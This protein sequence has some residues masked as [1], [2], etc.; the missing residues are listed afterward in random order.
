VFFFY[1][2]SI[3]EL[4]ATAFLWTPLTTAVKAVANKAAAVEAVGSQEAHLAA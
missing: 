3:K 1:R 2:S 4:L